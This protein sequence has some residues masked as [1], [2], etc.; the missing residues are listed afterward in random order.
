VIS[1]GK[2]F[3]LPVSLIT[4]PAGRALTAIAWQP[5]METGA[6]ARG[7][8]VKLIDCTQLCGD[9]TE[10]VDLQPTNQ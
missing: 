4:P 1:D 10:K 5:G 6:S 2:S 8:C 3:P 7:H 9:F